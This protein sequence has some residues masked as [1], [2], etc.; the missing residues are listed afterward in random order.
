M[1][2]PPCSAG[3]LVNETVRSI[4]HYLVGEREFIL[5]RNLEKPISGMRWIRKRIFVS[6]GFDERDDLFLLNV[7]D[8]MS[9]LNRILRII[10]CFDKITVPLQIS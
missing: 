3:R 10:V 9:G 6:L 7:H 4:P 2:K 8:H 1:K 5:F